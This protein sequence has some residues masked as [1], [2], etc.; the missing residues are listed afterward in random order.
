MGIGLVSVVL[1]ALDRVV[2]TLEF[3]SEFKSPELSAAGPQL[4]KVNNNAVIINTVVNLI[5]IVITP[6]I[7]CYYNYTI[8]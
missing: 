6:L 7:L 4:I 1:T 8:L 2:A 3:K 5:F